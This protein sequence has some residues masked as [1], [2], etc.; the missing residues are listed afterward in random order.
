MTHQSATYP[1]V[2][3]TLHNSIKHFHVRTALILLAAAFAS[4]MTAQSQECPQGG[5]R[6]DLNGLPLDIPID[7]NELVKVELGKTEVENPISSTVTA[8]NC[9]AGALRFSALY[10]DFG[11]F[12]VSPFQGGPDLTQPIPRSLAVRLLVAFR[13]SDP[14]KGT[15]SM[16]INGRAFGLTG[17]GLLPADVISLI[18][19]GTVEP[20][21]QLRIR[22]M[23]RRSFTKPLTGDIELRFRAEGQDNQVDDPAIQFNQNGRK[24]SFFLAEGKTE[25][26]F[27]STGTQLIVQTGTVA[28]TIELPITFYA[29]QEV[30]SSA[31]QPIKSLKIETAAPSIVDAKITRQGTSFDLVI[32]AFSTLREITNI[33]LLVNPSAGSRISQDVGSLDPVNTKRAFDAYYNTTG[34]VFGGL[35]QVTIRGTVS[36]D[37]S[38]VASMT[39]TMGNTKGTVQKTIPF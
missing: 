22:L 1:P 10:P 9:S 25:A 38:A 14:G 11:P 29:D 21:Q 34:K 30:V 35:F 16:R 2:D 36:G 20:R 12:T 17:L 39:I 24:M 7:Q 19:E 5:W 32:V 28:G 31:N 15:G 18:P 6:Y 13:P 37:L 23:I 27:S 26:E 3:R 8:L 4:Q 33:G